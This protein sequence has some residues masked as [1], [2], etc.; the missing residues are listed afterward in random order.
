MCDPNSASREGDCPKLQRP[1]GRDGA[2]SSR[3]SVRTPLTLQPPTPGM[4]T[5]PP[6]ETETGFQHEQPSSLLLPFPRFCLAPDFHLSPKSQRK[7][8]WLCVKEGSMT[9]PP[10]EGHPGT[11]GGDAGPGGTGDTVPL[12]REQLSKMHQ[13]PGRCSDTSGR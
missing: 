7:G 6:Q 8:E 5:F 13:E 2:P 3:T 11:G 1:H 10:P 12:L 9:A 4:E